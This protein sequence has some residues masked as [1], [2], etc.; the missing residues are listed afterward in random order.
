[1]GYTWDNKG[2]AINL[3][4]TYGNDVYTYD[5][6]NNE[7]KKIQGSTTDTRITDLMFVFKNI[8]AS[9][10]KNNTLKVF[11]NYYKLS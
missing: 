1:M 6:L 7:L 5:A 8:P 2:S 9:A 4:F 11:V 10:I 3:S